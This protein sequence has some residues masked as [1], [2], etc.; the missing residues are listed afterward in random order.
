MKR[1][2]SF[3]SASYGLTN[4]TQGANI[5]IASVQN[6]T[7]QS[8]SATISGSAINYRPATGFTGTDT[9]T[10]TITDGIS[11]ATATITVNPTSLNAADDT[12][13]TTAGAA[14]TIEVRTFAKP[15]NSSYPR[16]RVSSLFS[17][18]LDSRLRGNDEKR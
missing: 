5:R 6:P 17:A 1:C 18:L 15:V 14:T 9:F 12:T 16:K 4:D 3:L 2:A 10:Y 8:G 7:A 11:T 13:A